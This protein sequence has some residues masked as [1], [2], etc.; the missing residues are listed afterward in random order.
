MFNDQSYCD[1]EIVHELLDG[2]LE[3][4]VNLSFIVLKTN[5]LCFLQELNVLL[6]LVLSQVFPPINQ[7]RLWES[8]LNNLHVLQPDEISHWYQL[9]SH[10]GD[11]FLA[12]F[13]QEILQLSL[14]LQVYQ[15]LLFLTL[16]N[17]TAIWVQCL[18]SGYQFLLFYLKNSHP[19][20]LFLNFLWTWGDRFHEILNFFVTGFDMFVLKVALEAAFEG[21]DTVFLGSWC[22]N[23]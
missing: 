13:T 3:I 16:L 15:E 8:L 6:E 22:R 20:T 14:V 10:F 4:G 12:Y 2:F 19:Q 17:S 21:T 7:L 1:K 9:A 11:E 23:H 5:F 18:L